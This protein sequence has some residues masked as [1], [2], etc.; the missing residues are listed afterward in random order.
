MTVFP[1]YPPA[2]DGFRR[3]IAP[4]ANKSFNHQRDKENLIYLKEVAWT[5]IFLPF[6]TE[7]VW[8]LMTE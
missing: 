3:L 8:P 6:P 5:A 1:K 2:Y 4:T 7:R